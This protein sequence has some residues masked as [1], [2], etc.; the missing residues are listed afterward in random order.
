MPSLQS[1]AMYAFTFHQD[2]A[3]TKYAQAV[4]HHM[5]WWS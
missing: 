2:L 1:H 5:V 4:L 3:S